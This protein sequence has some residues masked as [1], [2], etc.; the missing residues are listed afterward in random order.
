MRWLISILLA[1]ICGC[2]L[3]QSTSTS[4][5]GGSDAGTGAECPQTDSCQDCTS[6]ALA[7]ACLSLAN[8]CNASEDCTTID[9]CFE[10]CSGDTACE[11]QCYANNPGG[12]ADYMS[13][14][15]CVNCQQCPTSC[16]GLC[17]N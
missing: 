8:T 9:Q 4:G 6:C 11:Q 17:T 15:T 7:G 14:L 5:T 1:T 2:S 16:S 13:L 10:G 12:E 3:A